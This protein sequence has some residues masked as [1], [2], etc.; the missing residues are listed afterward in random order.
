M[1]TAKVSSLIVGS[2][3]AVIPI[4]AVVKAEKAHFAARGHYIAYG[5]HVDVET[6]TPAPGTEDIRPSPS[7]RGIVVPIEGQR[8]TILNFTLIPGTVE[9]CMSGVPVYPERIERRDA[10]TGEWTPY[11]PSTQK[12]CL[13]L[14]IRT[15]VI[16]PLQWFQTMPI[17][18]SKLGWFQSGDWVRIVALSKCDKPTEGRREFAS[19]PFRLV[20]KGTGGR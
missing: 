5:W 9:A 6:V 13:N 14:P 11:T 3:M 8:A 16:W 10:V 1:L 18:I 15:K 19:P 2:L 17:P 7:E 20:A 12:M 4:V